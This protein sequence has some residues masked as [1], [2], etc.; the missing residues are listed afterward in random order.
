MTGLHLAIDVVVMILCIAG[1]RFSKRR[2]WP[3]AANAFEIAA[4]ILPC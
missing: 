3:G 1:N 4:Y 2:N